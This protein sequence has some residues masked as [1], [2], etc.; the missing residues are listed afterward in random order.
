MAKKKRPLALITG[1]TS[2]I[3]FA[4]AH[5]LGKKFDLALTYRSK[6]KNAE[7]ARDALQ[8]AN[9]ECTVHTY[10]GPHMNFE[11]CERIFK[12]IVKDFEES[13]SV[14]VNCAGRPM[15]NLFL[16]SDFKLSEDMIS[17]HLVVSMAFARL[18]LPSMYKRKYGRIVNLSSRAASI[19]WRGLA[20][21]AAAKGGIE[22]FTR[23]LSA[24]VAH[25]GITVNALAAGI[26]ESPMSVGIIKKMKSKKVIP[27]VGFYG[28]PEDIAYF[29]DFL[30]SDQARYIS[31]A[32][33]AVDGGG[34]HQ[35]GDS[36]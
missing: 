36:F 21:Y 9:P 26:V 32:I 27:N 6:V 16:T 13:P 31:G 11:E 20:P 35:P 24:E 10:Q 12:I 29:V 15:S 34:I 17:E 4:S 7:A 22:S 2:G 5:L 33:L 1:G 8:K 19:S 14:L 25:R 30:C 3:G 28:Q 23:S 18:V